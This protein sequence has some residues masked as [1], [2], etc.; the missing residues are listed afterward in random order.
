MTQPSII[1]TTLNA[2]YMH[3]AFALRYLYANLGEL[4][5]QAQIQEYT[6]A[7]RS[8]D[9]V[10]QLLSQQPRIIGFSVY[11]WNVSETGE[12]I[13]MLKQIAP[14]TRVVVGGPEVS[15][16]N[17]LPE[18]CEEVDH[19]ITGP[20]EI[21]FAELCVD[22]LQN[23]SFAM[24]IIPG[25]PAELAALEL[26]YALYNEED[27]RNRLIYVEA[28]RGCPF[29]CE[30]CLS[31]LD[32]TAKPFELE[33]FLDAM[34]D[35]YQRGARNFKFIDRTFNLKVSTSIAILE[36]FLERMD[37][38]LYLHFEVIPDHLPE[39]LKAVLIR[40]PHGQLQ[41][42]IGI[43]TFDPEIQNTIS[44][45]QDNEKSCANLKWIRENTGAHIHADLIFGLPGDSLENFSRSFDQLVALRPQEIQLGILKRLRGAPLNRHN[46]AF[47]LRYNPQAPYNILSTRDIDFATMQRVNRFAR[48]WDMIANSGRF[49]QTLP[50]IMSDQPFKRFMLLSDD[51]FLR[52][53]STW[54]IALRRLF[55]LLFLVMTETL[56][57]ETG[58]VRRALES[59]FVRSGQKGRPDFDS[60]LPRQARSGVA[61][62]RQRQHQPDLIQN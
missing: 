52:S 28:S 11:I 45:K 12:V 8:I 42:E 62:K 36:F 50:L 56:K 48:F 51:L 53:G 7:Q 1:L 26:P 37:E 38:N 57:I 10:E 22:L 13:K 2:R 25:K 14:D 27:I 41:F 61:N 39:K 59:D 58:C 30:F 6:I 44:R 16:A 9:I 40:F 20:G 5:A 47:K 31:S 49:T 24:Q 4:Q 29:K 33:R 55:E 17:D 46:E 60:T 18:F 43:Q 3:C 54:K 19:V 23:R 35:L 32:K 15:F 21:S 34:D